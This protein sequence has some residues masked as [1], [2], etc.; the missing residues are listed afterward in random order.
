VQLN[1]LGIV[2]LLFF[3]LGGLGMA[4]VP[5]AIGADP[6]VAGI[7]ALIGVIWVIVA[8]GLTLYA[9]HGRRRAAHQDRI[10]ATGNRGT[11][12]V[13]S[14][15]SWATFNEMPI[16]KLRLELDVPGVGIHHAERRETMPVFTANR[17]VPGLVL[18][19][20]FDPADPGDFVLVW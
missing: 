18:P 16:M 20:Y 17:M 12:T 5:V 19:A 6:Q 11:A 10:F 8:A 14:A 15:G 1:R 3:G 9:R 2:L 7:L 13:L 4:I